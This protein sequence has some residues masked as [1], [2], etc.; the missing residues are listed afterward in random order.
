MPD[1]FPEQFGELLG[2]FEGAP[3][4]R[5]I[6]G[7]R[8]NPPETWLLGSSPQS[9]IWAAELGLTHEALYRTLAR[10]ERSGEIDVDGPTLSIRS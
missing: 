6:P 8:P 9:A 10:M 1:D 5:R 7:G 4:A 3:G 2:Y